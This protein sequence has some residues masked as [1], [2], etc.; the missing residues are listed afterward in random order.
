LLELTFVELLYIMKL[1]R[2]ADL[3][4]ELL[5]F[6]WKQKFYCSAQK[7]PSWFLTKYVESNLILSSNLH[8]Y[9]LSVLFWSFS[10]TN[11]L[12]AFRSAPYVLHASSICFASI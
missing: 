11:I 9:L 10:S 4:E 2:R 5:V 1:R 7:I 8:R 6:F 12:N 3:Y